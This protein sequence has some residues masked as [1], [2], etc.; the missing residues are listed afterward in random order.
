[1]KNED[2]NNCPLD[3]PWGRAQT[4]GEVCDGVRGISTANHGGFY[5]EDRVLHHIP[6]PFRKATFTGSPNW[7]EEDVDGAI[8][9]MCFPEAFSEDTVRSARLMVKLCHSGPWKEVFEKP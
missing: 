8:V 9:V 4:Y 1:V 2:G 5:V 3:T 6:E 7:Y